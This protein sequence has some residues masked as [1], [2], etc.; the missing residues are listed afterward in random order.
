MAAS[1][2]TTPEGKLALVDG[3]I[4]TCNSCPCTT[5]CAE[6]QKVYKV[7]YGVEGDTV[8]VYDEQVK[9]ECV[10]LYFVDPLPDPLPP[11]TTAKEYLKS[12]PMTGYIG[13]KR[14]EKRIIGDAYEDDPETGKTGR[15]LCEE[16]NSPECYSCVS[17][18]RLYKLLYA[19]KSLGC[20]SEPNAYHN[21][22]RCYCKC[23][24]PGFA[25]GEQDPANY[26][27]TYR[28]GYYGSTNGVYWKITAVGGPFTPIP[29][30]KTNWEQCAEFV[31]PQ[32]VTCEGNWYKVRYAEY[33]ISNLDYL[34]GYNLNIDCYCKCLI[35]NQVG[36]VE[37]VPEPIP[38][39]KTASDYL[40][41][42]A[43]EPEQY[44]Y[45]LVG[46][47]EDDCYKIAK[48]HCED[49]QMEGCGD[50]PPGQELYKI[51]YGELN[52][53]CE[54]LG[55]NQYSLN[56]R[57]DCVCLITGEVP[58]GADPT[59]YAV[60]YQGAGL[61]GTTEGVQWRK[62][63]I[64]GPYSGTLESS[65]LQQ[66]EADH[67]DG[68][69]HCE[70]AWYI[71]QDS[72]QDEC[73]LSTE[74]SI[75]GECYVKCLRTDQ[76]WPEPLWPGTV[77]E[78]YVLNYPLLMN[79]KQI[80]IVNG[81]YTGSCDSSGEEDAREDIPNVCGVPVCPEGEAYG[82]I[83]RQQIWANGG[84]FGGYVFE[85][86]PTCDAVPASYVQSTM[87]GN[88]NVSFFKYP[89]TYPNQWNNESRWLVFRMKLHNGGVCS[90]NEP[91]IYSQYQIGQ[92]HPLIASRAAYTPMGLRMPHSLWCTEE[93]ARAKAN[94][95]N[96]V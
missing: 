41:F 74:Y 78:D 54:G 89:V 13:L 21:N 19:E 93:E 95:L 92:A 70:G 63:I 18:N 47:F 55:D 42:Y 44:R 61:T 16:A 34:D 4:V 29:G 25:V 24:F 68:C 1:L 39:G 80:T 31:V 14:W 88:L 20:D 96:G 77:P 83:V 45:D 71:L 8:G 17:P 3:K 56:T 5:G 23:L 27:E 46:P 9:C 35:S 58:V 86:G 91:I 94:E 66:C 76:S 85:S 32:C 36:G 2:W 48:E 12:Y 49:Y 50:C 22:V 11:G 82:V 28:N 53:A 75:K 62:W 57:C 73:D 69:E 87:W 33:N 30:G 38:E 67:V 40:G 72:Y 26:E 84:C 37:V 7:R 51:K 81:P 10:C 79:G 65:A 6:G 43:S 90:M 52:G 59:L 60:T 64:G 15:E